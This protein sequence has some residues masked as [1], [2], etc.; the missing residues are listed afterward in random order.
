[1][2]RILGKITLSVCAL[3]LAGLTAFHSASA[4]DIDKPVAKTPVEQVVASTERP[5]NVAAVEGRIAPHRAL[6]NIKL[7]S[8]KN[9]STISDITGK[10]YYA[11]S[12]DCSAWNVEQKMRLRFYYSEG[13]VSDTTS[14]LTSREAKDGSNYV[15]HVKRTSGDEK[16]EDEVTRGSATLTADANGLGTGEAA[17]TG[18]LTKD[19]TLTSA[20]TF[21]IHHTMQVLAHAQAGKRF[22]A[23]NVFDGADENGLNEI[24]SFIGNPIDATANVKKANADGGD[25]SSKG[26][27]TLNNDK[28]NY[29]NGLI[30]NPLLKVRGWPVRMA[31]FTPNSTMGSPD[32]EMDMVLLDNGVIR[33]MTINY[34]DFSM[35]A[36]LVNAE[37]LAANKCGAPQS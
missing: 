18:K 33:S 14:S 28:Q 27:R 34:D 8:T 15:F 5:I 31:F 25:L 9:G 37:P 11:W 16:G 7:S 1:M 26:D 32:Y 36:E 23:V 13:D 12:D 21:P 29:A 19:F 22:F 35:K 17:A 2:K 30:D 20:T 10:M 6:Y 3:G 4:N 24:S